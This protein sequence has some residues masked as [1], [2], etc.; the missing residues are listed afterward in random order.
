MPPIREPGQRPLHG[1]Q[2]AEP[3]PSGPI[4]LLPSRF[5]HRFAL[6][7]IVTKLE[8]LEDLA[9]TKD[10]AQVTDSIGKFTGGISVPTDSRWW[11]PL[12]AGCALVGPF[13]LSENYKVVEIWYDCPSSVLLPEESVAD[14]VYVPNPRLDRSEYPRWR[15]RFSLRPELAAKFIVDAL[16]FD[17]DESLFLG[18]SDAM[19]ESATELRQLSES[20]LNELSASLVR[21]LTEHPTPENYERSLLLFARQSKRLTE[22]AFD[23]LWT[24]ITLT[25]EAVKALAMQQL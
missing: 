19:I 14:S 23:A 3:P 22:S 16:I 11:I 4:D 17:V 21:E 13:K 15:T 12:P 2:P 9:G 20:R 8:E 25:P 10:V 6:S 5:W 18:E 24:A 1:W 7:H